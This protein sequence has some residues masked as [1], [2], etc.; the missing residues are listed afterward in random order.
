MKIVICGKGGIDSLADLVVGV[1]DPTYE[2]LTL[3]ERAEKLARGAKTDIYFVFNKMDDAVEALM[4]ER[5]PS[6]RVIARLPSDPSLFMAG[7]EG[8]PLPAGL[9]EIEPICRLVSDL[10]R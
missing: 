3:A 5:F 9:P 1:V 2:S 7:L 4:E 6:G 8:T 10:S